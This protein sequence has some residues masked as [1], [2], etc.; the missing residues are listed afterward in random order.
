[1]AL[2]VMEAVDTT[3]LDTAHYDVTLKFPTGYE[4]LNDVTVKEA[5]GLIPFVYTGDALKTQEFRLTCIVTNEQEALLRNLYVTTNHPGYTDLRYPIWITWGHPENGI[6]Y[7]ECYL[8][9]YEPPDSVNYTSA[10]ILDVTMVL[11]VI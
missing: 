8:A 11:R 4:I 9:E 3:Y 2:T 1:M 7:K 10:D 5:S 6:P